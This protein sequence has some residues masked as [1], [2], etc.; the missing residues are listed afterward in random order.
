[1]GDLT[2]SSVVFVHGLNGGRKHTW[3]HEKSEVYWPLDFLS[4][5][6]KETRIMS[7]GYGGQAVVG[8]SSTATF[9][10]FALEVLA[11]VSDVRVSDEVSVTRP[12]GTTALLQTWSL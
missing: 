11:L 8:R 4:K 1:M 2:L 3:T 10:D 7:I 6:L 12:V 5:D 9:R